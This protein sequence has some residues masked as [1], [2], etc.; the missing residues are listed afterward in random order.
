MVRSKI[1][2]SAS[3]VKLALRLARSL[4]VERGV[5]SALESEESIAAARTANL[6]LE[7]MMN[8]SFL[9]F[10]CFW[11]KLMLRCGFERVWR[12]SDWGMREV[13]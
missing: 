12:L 11:L 1:S 2:T 13:L 6:V 4:E 10:L 9:L 3:L 5:K 7:I 8:G